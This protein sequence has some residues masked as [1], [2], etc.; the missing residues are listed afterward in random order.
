LTGGTENTGDTE[1]R[2][3]RSE[4]EK[5]LLETSKLEL[6]L[7]KAPGHEVMSLCAFVTRRANK[8]KKNGINLLTSGLLYF[9]SKYFIIRNSS[10]FCW[11]KKWT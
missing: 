3:I 1:E 2:R 4:E 8:N 7:K 11:E 9:H 5:N 6:L 10:R